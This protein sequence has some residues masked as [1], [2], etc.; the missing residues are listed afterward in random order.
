M[1]S[2]PP[3]PEPA[4]S[5]ATHGSDRELRADARR[6]RERVR[7]RI[8]TTLKEKLM[9]RLLAATPDFDA[10]LDDVLHKRNNPHDAAEALLSRATFE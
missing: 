7:I 10:I 1:P 2:Q 4:K 3:E 6:N 8:E 5:L 9:N